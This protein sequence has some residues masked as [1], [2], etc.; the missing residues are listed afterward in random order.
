[1]SSRLY[2]KSVAVVLA[3]VGLWFILPRDYAR[4]CQ[5]QQCFDRPARLFIRRPWCGVDPTCLN[6]LNRG[7]LPPLVDNGFATNDF[8]SMNR[9]RGLAKPN[10]LLFALLLMIV[11][12]VSQLSLRGWVRRA[13]VVALA[14]IAAL[15]VLRWYSAASVGGIDSYFAASIG[16]AG[17]ATALA[18]WAPTALVRRT[19]VR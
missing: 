18:L 1:M 14:V 13:S 9:A 15:D 19:T 7:R 4:V 17:A 12:A 16:V 10:F 6:V 11:S 8:V 5:Q 3:F 2:L